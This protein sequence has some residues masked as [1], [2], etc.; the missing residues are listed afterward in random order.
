MSQEFSNQEVS[1]QDMSDTVSSGQIATRYSHKDIIAK[2]DHHLAHQLSHSW[3]DIDAHK[4]LLCSALT[5]TECFAQSPALSQSALF[6]SASVKRQLGLKH[7]MVLHLGQSDLLGVI[8]YNLQAPQ[9][10]AIGVVDLIPYHIPL[11]Q[12]TKLSI[13]HEL[14]H[15]Q[16][17]LLQD[18]LFSERLS[19]YQHEWLA[20]MYLFWHMARDQAGR[21]LIWQQLHRRNLAMMSDSSRISHWSAP[22]LQYLLQTYSPQILQSFTGYA[23]FATDAL[24]QIPNWNDDELAEFTSLVQRTFGNDVIQIL[25]RYMFWRQEQL[26]HTLTPTLVKLMGKHKTQ[27]WL[28]RQFVMAENLSL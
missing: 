7:A 14:G 18:T 15:L 27:L 6:S 22:Q 3:L 13:I 28:S 9:L 10:S 20:D 11:E 24:A 5:L 16:N 4:V 25:P 19:R 1:S 23:S 8:I 26:I 17:I 2:I 12:Q 21:D